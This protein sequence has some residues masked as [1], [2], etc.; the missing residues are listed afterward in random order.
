MSGQKVN[1]PS[2]NPPSIFL[3]IN[4]F[5][6]GGT[7]R[8]FVLL[9]NGLRKRGFKVTLGC[10][11]KTGPFLA[12]VGE[13]REFPL[14][15][16]LYAMRSWKSRWELI[17]F[18]R[19][20][21]VDLAHSF[22]LY[23]NLVLIPAARLA[24]VP[25]V[26][27][28]HRQLGDCFR[29]SQIRLQR[30]VLGLANRVV[31]NSHAAADT[32]PRRWAGRKVRII[33]NGIADG[34]F[35]G[36]AP[37]LPRDPRIIRIGMIA[38]MNDPVKNYPVFLRAA[39]RLA[40]K[41][42]QLEFVLA[43][44]G[45]LRSEL[46][47]LA[48]KLGISGRT[49]FLGERNDVPQVLA[50]MDISVLPSRSESLSNAIMESMAAGVPVVATRVGGN[51]ELVNDG[52]TGFLVPVNDDE[53]LSGALE[54][55]VA[56]PTLR[57]VFAKRAKELASARF[58]ADAMASQYETLYSSL[59]ACEKT[60]ANLAL[61]ASRSHAARVALVAPSLRYIGGQS[62]QADLLIRKWRDDPAVAM[63][64]IPVD[65]EFPRPL[66]W[67]SKVPYLRTV[68]RT[69]LYLFALWKGL[70]GAEVAHIF[71][72]SYWSFLLAPFPAWVLA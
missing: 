12:E 8:Q 30:L 53:R 28:S 56:D 31:C 37:A 18:L 6:T 47:Q 52:E 42:P 59:L 60:G 61:A 13:V 16:S 67:A 9:V 2:N 64:F 5:E 23:A 48:L 70:E 57:S 51:A 22:D 54:R 45:P 65:P 63:R 66:A 19:A 46:E 29:P 32:L 24:R 34:A 25:V 14:G 72:A 15:G 33:H 17:R 7:E 26:L 68:I 55:L 36:A 39:A 69:P 11:L 27:G 1:S 10:L 41:Y 4:S 21:R 3:M 49:R 38:R 40:P 58:S 50:S 20:H 43:G 44:D 71:S 62:A 35:A